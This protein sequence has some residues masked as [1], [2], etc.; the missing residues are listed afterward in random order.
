MFELVNGTFRIP[1]NGQ[2]K[3]RPGKL[4]GRGGAD[5]LLGCGRSEQ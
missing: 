1:E 4:G 3:T 2:Q 5:A